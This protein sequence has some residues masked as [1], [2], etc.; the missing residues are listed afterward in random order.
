[1]G[2][3]RHDAIVVTG[4][5][6]ER[7]EPARAKAVELGLPCSELVHSPSNGYVSFFIAPDGSKE[8]W[9]A[10]YRGEQA[11]ADWIAWARKTDAFWVDWAHVSYGGDD[12]QY[13][14]L[15]AHNCKGEE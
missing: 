1:M 13:A 10:S 4:W 11:R 7:V 3:I 12:A 8:G 14:S 15:K 5:D 6:K 2:Y 9:E